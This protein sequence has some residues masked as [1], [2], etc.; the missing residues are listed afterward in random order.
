[1]Y[2]DRDEVDAVAGAGD[3]A[4]RRGGVVAETGEVHRGVITARLCGDALG[5]AQDRDA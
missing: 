1:V 4:H 5:E 3:G 2:E